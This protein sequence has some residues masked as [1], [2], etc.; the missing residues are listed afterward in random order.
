MQVRRR[1]PKKGN[2]QQIRRLA[3]L[4][5]FFL[6]FSLFFQNLVSRLGFHSLYPALGCILGYSNACFTF[7]VLVRSYPFDVGDVC[8][9]FHVPCLGRVHK[10]Q[11]CLIYFSCTLLGHTLGTLAMSGLFSCC[12]LALCMIYICMPVDG[13]A[14]CMMD[15]H[16]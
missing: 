10:V 16:G 7:P 4:S 2:V 6:C 3:S 5:G 8:F 15:S 12:V 13:H 11:Q 1:K 9:I 14:L